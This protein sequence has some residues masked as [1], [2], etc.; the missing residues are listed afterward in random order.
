MEKVVIRNQ[1]VSGRELNS[2]AA[3]QSLPLKCMHCK[4]R[5]CVLLSCPVLHTGLHRRGVPPR[6]P[7]GQLAGSYGQGGFKACL[8][9]PPQHNRSD[10]CTR[11]AANTPTASVCLLLLLLLQD[12]L[13]C[14]QEAVFKP[15]KAIR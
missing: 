14:S 13:F 8:F 10:A 11:T 9:A 15:P 12:I 7:R 4:R 3:V 2:T 1:Q 6:S 5:V